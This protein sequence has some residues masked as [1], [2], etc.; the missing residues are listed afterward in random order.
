MDITSKNETRE[1]Q[2]SELD[3]L[4]SDRKIEQGYIPQSPE[5]DKGVL[6]EAIGEKIK[7]S[8]P[9]YAPRQLGPNEESQEQLT[10]GQMHTPH[11][12]PNE[13]ISEE[14][15][16]EVQKLI[17]I[18]FTDGVEVALKYLKQTGNLAL[19]DAYHDT[20]VDEVFKD[21]IERKKIEEVKD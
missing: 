15:I 6:H 19:I 8:I 7:E 14:L 18:T 11:Y 13:G 5:Q 21:L 1:N 3:K 2:V 9:E 16:P 4:A 20:L 17:N 10:S 12:C